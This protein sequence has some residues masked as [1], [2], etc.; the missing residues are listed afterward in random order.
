M[1]I[2][3]RSAT[4]DGFGLNF[5]NSTKERSSTSALAGEISGWIEL[6]INFEED[7][8]G[9]FYSSNPRQCP[10]RGSE[11]FDI[12][13]INL[14][15]ARIR[16]G[17]LLHNFSYVISHHAAYQRHHRRYPKASFELRISYQLGEYLSDIIIFGETYQ[18]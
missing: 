7:S 12:A 10:P 5:Y 8:N 15:I 14:H 2:E 9:L 16:Y 11:E 6:D 3:L 13:L 1:K 4:R 17:R 18:S